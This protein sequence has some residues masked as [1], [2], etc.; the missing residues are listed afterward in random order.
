[1]GLFKSKTLEERNLSVAKTI[2]VQ[3]KVFGYVKKKVSNYNNPKPTKL[4]DNKGSLPLKKGPSQVQSLGSGGAFDH[5]DS[6]F[7]LRKR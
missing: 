4:T 3:D 1:M 6:P 5:D 7:G 2:S